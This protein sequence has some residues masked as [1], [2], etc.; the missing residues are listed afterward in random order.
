MHAEALCQDV[1]ESHRIRDTTLHRYATFIKFQANAHNINLLPAK[2]AF[3]QVHRAIFMVTD[4]VVD[5]II[6]IW[7]E[8]WRSPLVEPLPEEL[9][10]EELPI[11]QVNAEEN[12]GN[13]TQDNPSQEHIEDDDDMDDSD[14]HPSEKLT[15]EIRHNHRLVYIQKN[16][17][18]LER[19]TKPTE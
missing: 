15:L 1:R 14:Q 3:Q 19:S 13:D 9:N 16:P 18:R 17:N 7:P 10:A 6:N 12:E 4:N 5:G 2:Y 11:H 8:K